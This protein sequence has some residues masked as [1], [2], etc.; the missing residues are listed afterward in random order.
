MTLESFSPFIIS[1]TT[2]I[3]TLTGVTLTQRSAR[4]SLQMQTDAAATLDRERRADESA[5]ELARHERT[6]E[7]ARRIER[8]EAYSEFLASVDQLNYA[9]LP[10]TTAAQVSA[11]VER[12]SRAEFRLLLLAPDM[13][14]KIAVIVGAHARKRLTDS[15]GDKA[16][17]SVR[18]STNKFIGQARRDLG[19]E[20]DLAGWSESPSK[21]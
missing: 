14:A 16:I 4:K 10:T 6:T 12:F 13:V 20:G 1:A 21:K 8:L 7:S 18:S 17:E 3:A 15:G 19:I 2:A 9:S 5:R 11:M